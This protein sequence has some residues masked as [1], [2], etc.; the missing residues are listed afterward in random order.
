MARDVRRAGSH[1]SAGPRV[2]PARVRLVPVES[3]LG[4]KFAPVTSS[5]RCGKLQLHG[6]AGLE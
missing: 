6:I 2:E 3:M 1:W 4:R 5:K